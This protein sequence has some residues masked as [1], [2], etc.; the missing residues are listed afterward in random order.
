MKKSS[1]YKLHRYLSIVCLI[2]VVFWCVSG[3]THPIMANWFRIKP[4]HRMA[5]VVKLD[6]AKIQFSAKQVALKN[7]IATFQNLG[8]K[9]LEGQPYYTFTQQNKQLFFNATTG[10]ELNNG[11]VIYAS[12]LAKYYLGNKQAKVTN[13]EVVKNFTGEYKVINRHLPAYKVSFNDDAKSDVYVHIPS[14]G[15]GTI[16]NN[17]KRTQLWIFSNLHNWDFLGDNH[18]VKPFFIFVL[19]LVTLIVGIL[20]LYIYFVNKKKF[21]KQK[22]GVEKLKRRN[23]HRYISVPSSVFFI[24]FAFSGGYHAF[25]KF[26]PYNLNQYQP[27]ENYTDNIIEQN[28]LSL[29]NTEKLQRISL[30]TINGVHYYRASYFRNPKAKYFKTSNLE[31]LG[32]GDEIYAMQRAAEI[33]NLAKV[34]INE[35]N[36]ITRFENKYGFINK[37]L[38]V[39]EVIFKDEAGTKCYV[40]TASGIPGALVNNAKKREALSFIMLHK[41]HFLDFLG[42]GTR[43]IIIALAVLSVL[44]I[45]YS[46][47][48]V[49]VQI[50][51]NR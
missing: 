36:S 51:K 21:K 41:F 9:V 12:Y 27:V 16:N 43:D 50:V 29:P 30:V 40:E 34:E 44:L 10:V 24:M 19:S 39:Y 1:L 11:A 22:N 2:P 4:A 26:E 38:P 18:T 48:R 6:T 42:K 7:K 35:V 25:Q 37:R 13:V 14:G 46:G 23:I 47:L 28:F 20:G 33:T 8:I 15:L 5:P 45:L 3:L 17:F 49:F 31:F 32:S